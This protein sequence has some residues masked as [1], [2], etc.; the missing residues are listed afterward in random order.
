MSD[1]VLLSKNVHSRPDSRE[2]S[3]PRKSGVGGGDQN[4]IFSY[5]AQLGMQQLGLS[6]HQTETP[7]NTKALHFVS[8]GCIKTNGMG[9]ELGSKPDPSSRQW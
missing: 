2:K 5:L 4:L 1:Q 3:L 8:E 7:S 9:C 6:K